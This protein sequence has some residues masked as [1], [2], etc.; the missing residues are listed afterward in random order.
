MNKSN[1]FAS[2]ALRSNMQRRDMLKLM[3]AGAAAL[4][5]GGLA[6]TQAMADDATV[7]FW[8]TATLDIGDKW[9]EFTRQSGVSPEFTDNGNDVGPVVARLAA[10][11]ANDLFDVGG[12]QGGAERELA[13]QGLIAPWDVSKI[14]NF[15]GIW[16]WAKD[17]PTLTYEGKQ[18]GI[19]TVV[20]ADSIIYRPDKLGKVDSYGVIFDPKLKGRVA[21]EDA[22]INSAIFTAIYLKEAENKPIKEPGNLT[23]SELGLVM[24]FLIKHK[25]DGQFRTFWNGWEQGVQLVA[26]EEVDAMTGWEP[27]VYEGR[28]RGLQVEYAAPVEGYEG[29][30]NNTVLLKGATERGKGDVAH[31]FVDGLLAGLYG[32]ELGKA[33]GYLVPTD[34]NLAYAKAHPDEYKADDVAKLADHVKAKFSGKV[35]W[36]NCRPDNFQLYEE[37]WQKLR[38]A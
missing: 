10:G 2:S 15:A 30:G 32:C 16:Q 5:F 21:M 11:N 9:Q 34:N 8:A 36:Q 20:N 37:W 24:E 19:P 12:F 35:Y 27:I 33:R 17:I 3:G 7:A 26:N 28:K 38:N 25:K 14:P 1:D 18:Y 23:E 6:A 13:K 31:K 22:W 29:W 4:S